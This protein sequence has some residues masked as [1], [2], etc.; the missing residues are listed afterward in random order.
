MMKRAKKE[1]IV[2]K[3]NVFAVEIGETDL[4][5][6]ASVVHIKIDNWKSKAQDQYK[7]SRRATG[8]KLQSKA[9]PVINFARSNKQKKYRTN[10]P[11]QTA[12]R[13]SASEGESDHSFYHVCGLSACKNMLTS[14]VPAF[15]IHVQYA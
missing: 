5:F 4:E 15:H 6:S 9:I 2:E 8:S 1:E 12:S 7:K 14:R 11:Y 13:K 10:R 3:L